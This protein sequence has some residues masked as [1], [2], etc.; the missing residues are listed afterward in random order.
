MH[1][2]GHRIFFFF[3]L[4]CNNVVKVWNISGHVGVGKGTAKLSG[5][6]ICPERQR[7]ALI[8]LSPWRRMCPTGYSSF[9][10]V[11]R[12]LQG[13]RR[14]AEERRRNCRGPNLRAIHGTQ[15]VQLREQHINESETYWNTPIRVRTRP[16]LSKSMIKSAPELYNNHNQC[17]KLKILLT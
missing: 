9:V 4:V 1:A 5:K 13:P 17:P 8:I 7:M 16:F 6:P 14:N 12:L 15:N 11:P 2:C 10:L 3:F